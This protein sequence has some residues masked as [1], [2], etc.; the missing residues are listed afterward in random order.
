M[1]ETTTAS[2][3]A[4]PAARRELMSG[5]DPEPGVVQARRDPQRSTTSPGTSA[6]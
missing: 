2:G 1:S 6:A 5:V 3:L 4:D